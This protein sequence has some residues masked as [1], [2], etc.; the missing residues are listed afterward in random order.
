MCNSLNF[1]RIHDLIFN[2]LL[3]L[4]FSTSSSNEYGAN[5]PWI[6]TN[7]QHVWPSW[8]SLCALN[9]RQTLSLS[10]LC[11][12]LRGWIQGTWLNYLINWV[13]PVTRAPIGL[14]GFSSVFLMHVNST[15]QLLLLIHRD[16][17][18]WV[19]VCVCVGVCVFLCK[20]RDPRQ[21]RGRDAPHTRCSR[22][23]ARTAGGSR[24]AEPGLFGG[25]LE[26]RG[27]GGWGGHHHTWGV[28]TDTTNTQS[29]SAAAR[30]A[31]GPDAHSRTPSPCVSFRIRARRQETDAAAAAPPRPLHPAS[32]WRGVKV[33]QQQQRQQRERRGEGEEPPLFHPLSAA[34]RRLPARGDG[35]TERTLCQRTR[36]EKVRGRP[37]VS[38]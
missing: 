11:E 8:W 9:W 38:R 26:R 20:V 21:E 5:S 2:V 17:Y 18:S 34:T 25:T 35:D 14:T 16:T 29:E 36:E 12:D 22:G 13:V 27:A 6:R 33:R 1:S 30:R 4:I 10:F 3:L 15:Q 19:C 24:A 7:T 32:V 31:H 37:V 28:C 23:R